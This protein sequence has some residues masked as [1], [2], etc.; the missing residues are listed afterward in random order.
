MLM[1]ILPLLVFTSFAGMAAGAYAV[2][3]VRLSRGEAAANR[4][5]L[6]PSICVVLLGIGLLGTLAH[7]GQPLRFVNGLSNPASMISQEAYWSIALGVVL[8]LDAVL[9]KVKGTA[10]APLRWVGA[11]VAVGL[12]TVT[13][14][15]YFRSLGL[16]AWSGAATL[17][18]FVVGDFVLGAALCALFAE[19]TVRRGILVANVAF[20]AAWIAVLAAYGLY[21]GTVGLDATAGLVVAGVLSL[22]SA[23]VALAA[24]AG[25]LPER[26]AA[27]A[28]I[29]LTVVGVVIARYAF[30]A[31]GMGA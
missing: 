2:S 17:P 28:L 11:L 1:H 10:V 20:A 25:A 21:L 24:L 13:G 19:G 8:V 26:T 6:F 7:L 22:A 5:W 31:L 27:I 14:M 30:F 4:T 9:C 3:A 12:M 29:V 18:L 16:E 23:G 15:A